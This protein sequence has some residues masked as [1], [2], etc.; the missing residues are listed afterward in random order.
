M[1]KRG[2]KFLFTSDWHIAHKNILKFCPRGG[3][4]SLDEMHHELIR[5][6]NDLANNSTVGYFLGDMCFDA[7][8]GKE[9]LSQLKGTKVLVRGNHDFKPSTMY[10]MGFDSVVEE[11]VV[12]V[13]GKYIRLSHFPYKMEDPVF[14]SPRYFKELINPPVPK[15]YVSRRPLDRGGWLLHGHTHSSEKQ[16]GRMIHVGVDAWDMK[17]ATVPQ[18]ESL[19]A[20]YENLK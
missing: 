7:K 16:T 8:V 4:Q 3:V 15:R 14:L 17:P 1:A 12:L 19:I 13:A 9:V 20:K 18:L 10:K 11:A 6:Y 2:N 5:N